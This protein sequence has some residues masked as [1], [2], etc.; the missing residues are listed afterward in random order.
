MKKYLLTLILFTGA[1]LLSGSDKLPGR[2]LLDAFRKD[3]A[4]CKAKYEDG[5]SDPV[6]RRFAFQYYLMHRP[7]EA[8]KVGVYD[9][10]AQIRGFAVMETF[11]RKGKDSYKLLMEK[12]SDH[13]GYVASRVL[14]CA[15]MFPDKALS[16]KLLQT[17][18]RTSQVLAVKREAVRLADFPFYRNNIRLQDSPTLDHVIRKFKTIPLPKNGWKFTTDRMINGHRLGY[19]NVGFDDKNWKTVKVGFWEKQG[20][21]NYNG[22][23]WYRIRFK[24]PP[25]IRCE[26]A[27]LAFGA[28]DEIAW[29]WLNG[30]YIG[31]H[32]KGING[33]DKPFALDVTKELNWGEENVLTV[34]VEDTIAA[35]GI[36][37]PIV[38]DL[39]TFD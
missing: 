23:A 4:L 6:L 33:W 25:R 8:L 3:A 35:G 32:D 10:D 14:S 37:K 15:K 18:A 29:V 27:E 17:L 12:T 31:K 28:V 1:L 26:A 22:Y 9:R 7:E 36:W 38:L 16:E 20:F 13:N 39:L 2:K 19:F 11:R 34:R 21:A 24:L 5:K 30:T